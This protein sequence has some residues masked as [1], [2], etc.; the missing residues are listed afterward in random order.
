MAGPGVTATTILGLS[1]I[2]RDVTVSFTVNQ[3][4]SRSECKLDTGAWRTCTS[5]YTWHGLP[6]GTHVI[7]VRSTSWAGA[8]ETTAP[9]ADGTETAQ[10]S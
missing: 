6:R 4:A 3:A 10:S 7:Q 9:T 5:G 8:L 2:A 1:R